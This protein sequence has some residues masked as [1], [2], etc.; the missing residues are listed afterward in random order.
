LETAI[1]QP[2]KDK[3]VVVIGASNEPIPVIQQFVAQQRVTFPI[4]HDEGGVL[5]NTLYRLDGRVSPYP[6]DF[7]IDQ[8]GVFQYTNVEYDVRAM[9]LVL[10]SL[11]GA[12]T[13][14]EEKDHQIQPDHYTLEQNYPNPFNPSTTISFTLA[15]AGDIKIS[16]L[17]L[18][19]EKVKHLLAGNYQAGEYHLNWDG[20]NDNGDLLP[21]G[22]YF[23]KMEGQNFVRTKKMTF[24]R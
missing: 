15:R 9:K 20:T 22:I 4:I 11:V 14:I 7:I 21:S 5:H 24:L 8:N 10:E 18:L 12:P 3:G 16:I 13:G 1:W 2:F 17:N 6:R 19:G 23:Y